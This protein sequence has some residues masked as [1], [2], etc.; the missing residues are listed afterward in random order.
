MQAVRGECIC[1]KHQYHSRA[2]A[3]QVAAMVRRDR[4][5][6]VE[7][8]HCPFDARWW[9]I[10]HPTRTH[11][12]HPSVGPGHHPPP[13]RK[14]RDVTPTGDKI[15][16]PACAAAGPGHHTTTVIIGI[17]P[18]L[19]GAI[20]AVAGEQLLWAEDMPTADGRVAIPLLHQ[21]L[22]NDPPAL[23]AV[24]HVHSMPKQGV[25]STFKFGTAYGVALGVASHWRTVHVPP[26]EWKKTFRLN[27][28]GKDAARALAIELWPA[29]AALFA[30]KARG[31]AR[32]DAALIALHTS[33][34]NP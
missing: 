10:G 11:P 19:S 20:A 16:G 15:E 9:H 31:Q 12:P 2:W 3:R 29:H 6:T 23:V 8:Y 4:S 34:S 14:E 27:G 13:R 21:I 25:S 17:D 18:G 7:A 22:A 30:R 1:G 26:T 28:K 33:R 32:A 5:T 24:E